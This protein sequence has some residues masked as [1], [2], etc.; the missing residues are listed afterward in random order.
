MTKE[1]LES[2][3]KQ[4]ELE[5]VKHEIELKTL[6]RENIIQADPELDNMIQMAKRQVKYNKARLEAIDDMIKDL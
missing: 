1:I 3:R 2:F 4:Y 5:L 6:Q